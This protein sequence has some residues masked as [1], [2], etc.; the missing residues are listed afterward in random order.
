VEGYDE[1]HRAMASIAA[2]VAR[3][4][5]K[6]TYVV[7]ADPG[8]SE[9]REYPGGR[10]EAEW[11]FGP[12]LS[13]GYRYVRE[14]VSLELRYR[15]AFLLDGLSTRG[16]VSAIHGLTFSVSYKLSPGGWP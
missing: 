2:V 15:G 1:R 14:K 12:E 10:G 6:P 4:E 5:N 16:D 8:A 11:R 13:A 3:V 9:R 7:D